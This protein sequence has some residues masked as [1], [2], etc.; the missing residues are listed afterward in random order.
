MPESE[1][2]HVVS[3]SIADELQSSV[4][5]TNIKQRIIVTT[6]DKIELCL[7]RYRSAFESKARWIGPFS[8]ACSFLLALATARFEPKYGV[9]APVWQAIF[10]ILFL[11]FLGWTAK[12]VVSAFRSS[13]LNEI[14]SELKK[15]NGES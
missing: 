7:M 9:D 15:A 12:W 14:I 2:Q 5:H 4:I 1:W 6:E 3:I 13:N 8:A 10:I 11:F